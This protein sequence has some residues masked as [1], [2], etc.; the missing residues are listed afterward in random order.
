MTSHNSHTALCPITL[1]LTHNSH[2][3]RS[4]VTRLGITSFVLF[5]PPSTCK[6]PLPNLPNMPLIASNPTPR[7]ILGLMTFGPDEST[8]K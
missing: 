3:S 4:T 2:F 6:K 1:S 7:V 8:G 5:S